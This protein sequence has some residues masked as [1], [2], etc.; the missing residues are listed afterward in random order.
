MVDTQLDK[1]FAL[2]ALSFGLL[3][4]AVFFLYEGDWQTALL[5][6]A[7]IGAVGWYHLRSKMRSVL[8]FDRPA[9][10]VKLTVDDRNGHQEWNWVLSD[11]QSAEISEVRKS[12]E[13]S[14][15]GIKQPVMVMKNGTRV[16]LR[17]YHSAGGM[18]FNAVA[19]IQLFLG[20]EITGAP[21]GWL[22][23]YE[24]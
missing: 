12:G 21:V 5:P 1:Q 11:V 14:G 9:N 24:D 19:A 13:T 3:L 23:P 7:L 20:Q 18:S 16:P 6:L 15:N 17:P 2:A 10:Q 8:L 4:V 22:N